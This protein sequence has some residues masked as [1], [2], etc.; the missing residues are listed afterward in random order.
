M[1]QL[2]TVSKWK[3][4]I[5]GVAESGVL[6]LEAIKLMSKSTPMLPLPASKIEPDPPTL[7]RI[8]FPWRTHRFLRTD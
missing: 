4:R 6:H 5:L 1:K 7:Q 2:K 8:S 3:R